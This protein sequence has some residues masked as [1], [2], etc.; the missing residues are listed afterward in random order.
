M[1]H[2]ASG[3]KSRLCSFPAV[4]IVL[5]SSLLL[6]QSKP[7]AWVPTIEQVNAVYPE[8]E[9][10]Y[11]DLHRSPELSFHEQQTA[12]KL[13][14]RAKVW[15]MRWPSESA[16]R[17]SSQFF[18]METV[19]PSCIANDPKL[20]M[21]VAT[22]LRGALGDANVLELPPKMVSEDFSE[23]G[24]AGVP[25]TMFF[26]GA[27]DPVKFAEAQKSGATL[28]G[29][30]SSLWAPAY[31]PTLKTAIRSETAVLVELLQ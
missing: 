21:R 25:S 6:G 20:T 4:L 28:P 26:V 7:A 18:A 10:L 2:R 30:H 1:S 15:D 9:A 5:S 17:E 14:S 12:A 16:E 29:L 27:V 13:A 31:E 19:P 24:L 8:V 11:L 3:P 23:F 22:T